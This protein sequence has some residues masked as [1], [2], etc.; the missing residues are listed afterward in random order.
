MVG[1]HQ[2]NF[3]KVYSKGY[4]DIRNSSFFGGGGV[5]VKPQT[6]P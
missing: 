3:G 1:C 4:T 6:I 5:N 2:I